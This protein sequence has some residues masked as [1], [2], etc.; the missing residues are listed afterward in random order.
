MDA[1]IDTVLLTNQLRNLLRALNCLLVSSAPHEREDRVRLA[2]NL[3]QKKVF[4]LTLFRILA[5]ISVKADGA[6]AESFNT[7]STIQ[8][9]DAIARSLE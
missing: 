8:A 2:P 6:G 1:S 5:K 9:N 4:Q 3:T 7:N